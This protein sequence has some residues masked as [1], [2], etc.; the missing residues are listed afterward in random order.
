MCL[1]KGA[2]STSV[3]VVMPGLTSPFKTVSV[4]LTL[5]ALSAYSSF[6]RVTVVSGIRGAGR[7]YNLKFVCRH[8]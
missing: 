6:Y 2:H 8:D 7:I 1:L 3:D 5:K 4:L